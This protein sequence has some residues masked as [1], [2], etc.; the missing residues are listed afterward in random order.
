MKHFPIFLKVENKRICIVG[1]GSDAVAKARLVSKSEALVEIYAPHPSDDLL[2][3]L[4]EHQDDARILWQKRNFNSTDIDDKARQPVAFAYLTEDA[5]DKIEIFKKAH[6][7]VCV[8][9]N[10]ELSHFTTPALVDRAPVVVAIGTEGTAPVLARHIKKH[11]EEWL[12]SSIGRL[13]VVA[14]SLRSY[15]AERLS[16]PQRRRFWSHYFT[17]ISPDANDATITS[18]AQQMITELENGGATP[19]T[20]KVWFV[21]AGPGDP[22]L[23]TMQ[24]RRLLHDADVV[25]HDRLVSPQVL[26]LCRREAEVIEVGKTGYGISW[27]QSDIND[28]L[29]A[30]AKTPQTVIRLKSGDAGIYGRLDEEINA[31]SQHGITFEVAPGLT[32]ASAGAAIMGAS[33][34][35][36]GRNAGYRVITGHDVNGFADYDWR[37]M[38]KGLSEEQFTASIYMSVRAASYLVGRLLMH[39]APA[40]LTVCLAE[41]ISRQNEKWLVSN[42]A[43]LPED[44]A[45]AHITGPAV[46]YLGLAPHQVRQASLNIHQKS[47][48]A[49]YVTEQA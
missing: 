23:L 13:A 18:S 4:T 2:H 25:L 45:S 15:V 40:E 5:A 10:L 21:G 12:P 1:N 16:P 28:L 46:I 31:L 47:S 43:Q 36:R 17:K 37:E 19:N 26:E 9:D 27:K 6:I 39:G 7:P 8:I 32:S 33:L 34:T 3:Y 41:N 35:R 11:L 22:D 44:I 42:L 14:N 24:A 20:P 49:R 29:V 38:A 48:E 30:R